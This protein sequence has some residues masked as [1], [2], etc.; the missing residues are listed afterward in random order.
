MTRSFRRKYTFLDISRSPKEHR[1]PSNS[2]NFTLTSSL[3]YDYSTTTP[4]RFSSLEMFLNEDSDRRRGTYSR[5]RTC[6]SESRLLRFQ[7]SSLLD[8]FEVL[9]P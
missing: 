2:F 1:K 9:G 5:A 3:L 7:W 8:R 6:S 4:L